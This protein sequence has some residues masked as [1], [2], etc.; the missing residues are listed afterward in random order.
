VNAAGASD[1]DRVGGGDRDPAGLAATQGK[2]IDDAPAGHVHPADVLHGDH[3]ALTAHS[4]GDPS[5]IQHDPRGRDGDVAR[6]SGFRGCI[7]ATR[8]GGD[9][10][11]GN[12]D[13]V[14]CPHGDRPLLAGA[15]PGAARDRAAARQ[16]QPADVN[17]DIAPGAPRTPRVQR[18]DR[19]AMRYL[20]R[21]P[22]P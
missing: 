11:A 19:P 14:A 5:A 16:G 2:A 9:T 20:Q 8:D 7:E 10:H 6:A 4:R 3:A 13:L 22:R 15:V 17:V 1:Q 18:I 12:G 21:P